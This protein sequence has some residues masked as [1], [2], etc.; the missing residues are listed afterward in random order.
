[1]LIEKSAETCQSLR[2][3]LMHYDELPAA[4]RMLAE[5]HLRHCENCRLAF[6]KMQQTL[7]A[8]PS[9]N[10]SVTAHD[11]RRISARVMDPVENQ[12][13][14]R[15]IAR[16]LAWGGALSAAAA[17]LLLVWIQPGNT[18]SPSPQ[19]QNQ[20]ADTLALTPEVEFLEDMELLEDF[21]MLVLLAQGQG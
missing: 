19:A 5:E 15:K 14:K 20:S 17:L 11:A 3:T 1:V 7:D 10:T 12:G 18:P 2:L 6:E 4:E 13:R 16:P 8:L 21:E 9:L